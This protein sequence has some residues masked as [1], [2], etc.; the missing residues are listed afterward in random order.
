MKQAM[1]NM[2]S[3][4]SN[5]NMC[6]THMDNMRSNFLGATTLLINITRTRMFRVPYAFFHGYI[7]CDYLSIDV[8]FAK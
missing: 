4:G 8:M 5:I 7:P 3:V 6:S 2:K 1:Y